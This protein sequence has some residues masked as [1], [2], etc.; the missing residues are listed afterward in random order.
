LIRNSCK[1]SGAVVIIATIA[2]SGVLL[3]QGVLAQLGLAETAAR[4]FLFSEIKRAAVNRRSEVVVAGNRAFLKLPPAARGQAATALFAWSKA[5][6]NS[7]AF[8]SAYANYRRDVIG[9]P[10]QY[11]HCR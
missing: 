3:A 11:G 1:A 4:S 2:A 9:K 7:P 5:Y 10:R 6:V 8:K